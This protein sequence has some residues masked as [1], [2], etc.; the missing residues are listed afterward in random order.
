MKERQL[1]RLAEL[2]LPDRLTAVAEGLK[3]IARSVEAQSEELERIHATAPRASL[4]LKTLAE[5][6]AAKAF[7]LIDY[8]R[9]PRGTPAAA[10]ATHLG[11]AY[12]HVAR[13]VYAFYYET[14][15]ASFAEVMEIVDRER[16]SLY[17]D[18]PEGFEWIFRNAIL[19]R[20]EEAMYVDWVDVEGE[21]RWQSPDLRARLEEDMPFTRPPIVELLLH[22]EHGGLLT[23]DSLDALRGVWSTTQLS[24]ETHWMECFQ[25]N[26]P[27][28]QL[29]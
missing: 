21:M 2:A 17:L 24:A 15:P 12:D 9:P 7:I 28:C 23:A 5:E 25:A 14:S 20:R 29:T 27:L 1:K 10:V 19:Q 16:V 18:G 11:R 6:E 26:R 3:A 13:G 8:L 4:L 22:M